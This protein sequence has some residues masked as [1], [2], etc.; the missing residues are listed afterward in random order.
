M[1]VKPDTKLKKNYRFE[2][3][4]SFQ[5]VSVLTGK[6][7]EPYIRGSLLLGRKLGML[8][9]KRD[10]YGYGQVRHKDGNVQWIYRILMDV[11]ISNSFGT[12]RVEECKV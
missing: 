2:I 7:W 1:V 6:D 9:K 4:L 5:H 8:K 3:T 12:D 11:Q 10:L